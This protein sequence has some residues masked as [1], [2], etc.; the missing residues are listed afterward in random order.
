MTN[1][2]TLIPPKSGVITQIIHIS[3]IHIR[4][5]DEITCRYEE[6]NYVFNK[7]F[8]SISNLESVNANSAVIVITGDTFHNKSKVETHGIMLFNTLI[9]NL[10]KL[11][12]VYIILGNHDFRQDQIENSIDFLEAFE[13]V[14]FKNVCYLK[15]TGLYEAANVGFGL[16]SVKDT[17]RL[18]AGSGIA[19]NIPDFPDPKMFSNNIKT[20]IAL[21]HGTM[22]NS[23][24][25][26][27]RTTLEGYPWNWMDVGY[28]FGLLGD[29]HKQQIFPTRRSGFKAAYSGSLIQQNFGESILNHGYLLWNIADEQIVPVDIPNKYG[30]LKLTI[31]NKEWFCENQTLDSFI[32]NPIFPNILKIRIFGNSG[33]AERTDL[34]NL[35]YGKEFFLDDT[36]INDQTSGGTQ[37]SDFASD[38][39]LDEYMK[40]NNICDYEVPSLEDLKITI[41]DTWNLE[42][43]KICHKKNLDIDKEYCLYNDSIEN[44]NHLEKICIKYIEWK[45]LLCYNTKNWFDFDILKGKT[46]L[47]SAKNGGGKSSFLEIICVSIFGKPI[48]SRNVKGN[49]YAL[50]SKNLDKKSIPYTCIHVIIKGDTFKISRFFDSLGRPKAR[51]GGVYRKNGEQWNTVCSDPPKTNEWVSEHLGDI[52]GFLMTTMV[53]QSNDND[54]LSMKQTEQKH[55]LEQI[56][57]MKIANSKA[58]LFKQAYLAIKQ[59]KSHYD[60]SCSSMSLLEN[61]TEDALDTANLIYDI[62]SKK[63]N[64]LTKNLVIDWNNC[65]ITDLQRE[66]HDI[67]SILEV[68]L[69]DLKNNTK[70]LN[71]LNDELKSA[72]MIKTN[73]YPPCKKSNKSIDELQYIVDQAKNTKPPEVKIVEIPIIKLEAAIG[74]EDKIN[75]EKRNKPSEIDYSFSKKAYSDALRSFNDNKSAAYKQNKTLSEYLCIEENLFTLRESARAGAAR[76]PKQNKE[77]V[78]SY[79][80]IINSK[81]NSIEDSKIKLDVLTTQITLYN[82]HKQL[83]KKYEERLSYVTQSI[84]DTENSLVNIPFNPNC[85]ACCSQPLRQ[86]LNKLI[87]EKKNLESNPPTTALAVPQIEYDE[88]V[89]EISEYNKHLELES[90][91][92]NCLDLWEKYDKYNKDIELKDKE[93]HEIREKI[94][95]LRISI[96]DSVGARRG[97][98]QA[99]HEAKTVIDNYEYNCSQEDKWDERHAFVA[100]IKAQWYLYKLYKDNES[101]IEIFNK[102]QKAISDLSD[103][104]KYNEYDC[105]CKSNS[106]TITRLTGKIDNINK[107]LYKTNKYIEYWNSVKEQ[108]HEYDKQR[109]IQH[110]IDILRKELAELYSEKTLIANMLEQNRKITEINKESEKRSIDLKNK[111]E[112]IQLLAHIYEQY[113]CWLYK[114]HILPKLINTTNRFVSKVEPNLRLDYIIKPDGSFLF[115]AINNLQDIQL[116]K[117]SGF[118]YFILAICLRLAFISL[119]IGDNKFGG[120]LLIDEGFTNCDTNHLSKIPEFLES[121]LHK[122]DSI[123]LVSHLEKIKDSVDN[124]IFISNKSL[125]YGN[126][127]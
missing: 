60:V 66:T 18:G 13:N 70:K 116:E 44:S 30:Y 12:P 20:T 35:L 73:L 14:S 57:G 29:I 112:H 40:S 56:F 97:Y 47:I 17:L 109:K 54:F 84:K 95:G 121:L 72:I 43:K 37:S 92:K 7:L 126:I 15:N 10:G 122:F 63:L 49:A 71:A 22:I 82:L 24:F 78:L 86:Q 1:N 65:K 53:S 80:S 64:D 50:I 77:D 107:E 32:K 59:F 67:N 101:E 91:Y 5:G 115:Q 11:A 48:P 51:K 19:D 75:S 88:L 46:N 123:I 27:N 16:V 87:E 38:V 68:Q 90:S 33:P 113:R 127:L 103:A 117:T 4:N 36:I 124:T 3:D 45:G 55:H 39:L 105:I 100:S 74:I 21:F 81:K 125:Q 96:E 42:L 69:R 118:E 104:I 62:K 83:H 25:T 114:E 8:L 94:R 120:Q 61:G 85:S 111:L 6:Y 93:L 98:E 26:E 31:R 79:I 89:F 108:K 34:R 99:L 23:K 102:G 28:N 110:R 76:R 9:S 106:K 119:T 41:D 2:I 52:R 58:A